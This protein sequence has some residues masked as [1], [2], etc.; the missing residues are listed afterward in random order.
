MYA[1]ELIIEL[2]RI[3][4]IH[5]DVTVKCVT[6]KT[7]SIASDV[8]YKSGGLSQQPSIKIIAQ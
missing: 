6:D 8:Y 2:Q 1:S 3:V 5:G 7:E 4:K